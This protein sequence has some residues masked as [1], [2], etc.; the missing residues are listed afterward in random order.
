MKRIEG[1]A[2][3]AAAA[4]ALAG[5]AWA[6]TPAAVE[7]KPA[8]QVAALQKLDVPA[9]A[10]RFND[11]MTAVIFGDRETVGQLL[12]FGRWVDRPDSNG[13]TPLMVAVH[14]RNYAMVHLLLERGANAGLQAPGGEAALDMARASGEGAIEKL[15]LDA[16]RR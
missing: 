2:I 14:L 11:V 16:V 3:L 10:P 13:L 8:T 7:A 9:V 6:Q 12:D 1:K 5:A 4:Y 15:L